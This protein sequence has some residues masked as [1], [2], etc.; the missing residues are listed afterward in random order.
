MRKSNN[1]WNILPKG[2]S[3]VL[4]LLFALCTSKTHA[5][6]AVIITDAEPRLSLSKSAEEYIDN[7][8]ISSWDRIITKR[9]QP[10]KG[11][12]LHYELSVKSVWLKFEAFN[13]STLPTLYLNIASSNLEHV[14]LFK[15]SNSGYEMVA[16]G[17]NGL[18]IKD[19]ILGSPDLVL[20]LNLPINQKAEYLVHVESKHPI[21]LPAYVTTYNA[22]AEFTLFQ[23]SI[24]CLYL[25][26][27]I[28]MFLYN[29]FLYFFTSDHNYLYYVIYIF[30]LAFAQ[31][32]LAGYSYKFLWPRQPEIND[33]AVIWT[34]SL[35]AV[36]GIVF[37]MI[38]LN[39]A[40]FSP[41][42]H[43]ILKLCIII[44]FVGLILNVINLGVYSYY[45]LN[46]I[47]LLSV[48]VVL[49]VSVNLAR[50]GFRPAI[51][52][53]I[54]WLALLLS[55]IVLVFSNINLLPHN[56]F[57][58]Y[59]FYIGSAIEVALLS[60][61]LAAKINVLKKEKET[62]HANALKISLENEQL[63]KEQNTVL[64]RKVAERTEELQHAN[65]DVSLAYKNLKDA[66]IQLVEAEK[67]ASLGQLTAGIA[68][69]I[70]N[71][72]NFV[73]SNIK[74]LQLDFKD[75][76]EVIDEYEKLH[77]TN[78][79]LVSD[80]LKE[81]EGLKK[82]I[83]LEFVKTEI[84]SLMKGIENGAERTAEIVRGLRTFSRLDESVIKTVDI[85]EGIDSTL[86]L[87]RSN[88]PVN[89]T[90]VKAYTATSEIE[91][92]PGKLNQVFMNILSNAIHAITAKA[93][94][95]ADELI[96]ITTSNL[97]NNQFEIRIKDTGKGMPEEVK[98][99]IFD[100]FFTTKD[101]GEGTGLGLAIV[102]KIIQEHFGK[103]EVSSTEG[104]GTEFVIT[105]NDTIPG[106]PV[107]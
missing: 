67:M 66:Q 73:K 15:K 31:L 46:Y 5:A 39:T 49:F 56:T 25:G 96:T 22:L 43:L 55:F 37:S 90:V 103:I 51:F 72:I 30:F 99:K 102:F 9:F 101:V 40:R 10:A 53:L 89:I 29:L 62:S 75:L 33:Y 76:M 20:N 71:P 1:L 88:M 58:G 16:E 41:K 4:F 3:V 95:S 105:L 93:T 44:Y 57:I 100:P 79:D 34:S 83:D 77:T 21:I 98:Q 42:A 97:A 12:T 91:C 19:G 60:L 64:E 13:N 80:R 69:E 18:P 54:A 27:L 50:T 74:P 84:G 63:V 2:I 6:P 68:H 82:S 59:A 70:N 11:K 47:G 35:A 32:T 48:L 78:V 94:M 65:D 45:I 24:I 14:T 61:A 104:E 86:I 85:H 26:I 8:H 92:Y 17:G 87:L 106:K 23:T 81:I 107:I 52:Y 28:I 38:F 7:N 36:T